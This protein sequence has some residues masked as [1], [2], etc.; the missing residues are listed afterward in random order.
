MI[1]GSEK[2]N[3]QLAFELQ[4]SHVC[5]K[6]SKYFVS[7]FVV[8]KRVHFVVVVCLVHNNS[9]PSLVCG[10]YDY[11]LV[12][13]SRLSAFC[14]SGGHVAAAR[15]RSHQWGVSLTPNN[16]KTMGRMTCHC[17]Q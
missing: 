5:E 8:N 7:L 12:C 9:H 3:R 2:R 6:R 17:L 10:Q 4:N 11:G 16:I 1:E 13:F 14:S 15:K